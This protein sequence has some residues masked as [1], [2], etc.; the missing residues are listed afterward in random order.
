GF[1]AVTLVPVVMGFGLPAYVAIPFVLLAT[2]L[3]AVIVEYLAYRPLR[4]AKRLAPLITAVGISIIL[5]ESVRVIAGARPQPFP[6]IFENDVYEVAS[7]FV[8]K[9]Q[10]VIFVTTMVLMVFLRWIVMSTRIG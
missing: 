8:Q 7:L 9:S 10:L 4:N 5:L 1:L 3:L 2:G 6:D